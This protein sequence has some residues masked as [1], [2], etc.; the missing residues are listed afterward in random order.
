[1][2]SLKSLAKFKVCVHFSIRNTGLKGLS[3]CKS[4]FAINL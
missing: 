3:K 2:S 1:L 4:N